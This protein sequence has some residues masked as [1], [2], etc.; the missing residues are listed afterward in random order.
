MF[1]VHFQKV[2]VEFAAL[3]TKIWPKL[4][5]LLLQLSVGERAVLL[6]SPFTPRSDRCNLSC[7]FITNYMYI[8]DAQ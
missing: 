6:P 1:Y 7:S 4:L 2:F 3:L 5:I 8:N